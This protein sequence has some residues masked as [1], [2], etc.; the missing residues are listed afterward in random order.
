[1]SMLKKQVTE[2]NCEANVFFLKCGADVLIDRELGAEADG[3]E[4]GRAH[5]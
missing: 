2:I 3:I 1:M 5:V 4:I